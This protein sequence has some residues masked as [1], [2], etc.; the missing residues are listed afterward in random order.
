MSISPPQRENLYKTLPFPPTSLLAKTY[1]RL[2]GQARPRML[3]D[4]EKYRY[5]RH[6]QLSSNCKTSPST[7]LTTP[8]SNPNTVPVPPPRGTKRYCT[9]RCKSWR[10]HRHETVCECK[11]GFEH[12]IV[13]PS[14]WKETPA[15]AAWDY[16]VGVRNGGWGNRERRVRWAGPVVTDVLEPEEEKGSGAEREGWEWVEEDDGEEVHIGDMGGDPDEEM[17]DLFEELD[18]SVYLKI[19]GC[20]GAGMLED[21]DSRDQQ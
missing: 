6:K 5:E 1:N 9:W 8:Y 11:C 12:D 18:P 4:L 16:S 15:E 21:A 7:S 14:E 3:A 10:R 13:H 19:N 17:E 2:S 20:T